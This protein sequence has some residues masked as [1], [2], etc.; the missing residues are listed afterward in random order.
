MM[1]NKSKLIKEQSSLSEK[2]LSEFNSKWACDQQTEND[3]TSEKF[4]TLKKQS[5]SHA[6]INEIRGF[7]RKK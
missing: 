3:E 2:L 5:S 1:N 7:I 6:R 4:A